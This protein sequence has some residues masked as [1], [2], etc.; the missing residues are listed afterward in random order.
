MIQGDVTTVPDQAQ[1]M[2]DAAIEH[3]KKVLKKLRTGKA[4]PALLDGV[5][6]EYYGAL[7]PLNQMANIVALDARSLSVQPWDKTA[8]APIERAIINSDLG[9]VP[10]ND[11]E[12]IHLNIPVLT[13][14]RRKD[15]AKQAR[16]YG[17][18]TKVGI[19]RARHEALEFIRQEVKDGFAED[20]AKR[21]EK[22]VEE[23]TKTYYQKVDDL[24]AA[25]EKEIMTV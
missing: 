20:D 25:K 22:K 2:M 24:V 17:E 8:V 1:A 11:G 5:M 4:T 23:L 16:H 13:E 19:R 6:V 7:T 14:E 18:E 15:L 21:L 3:L 12:V 10:Q 9:L